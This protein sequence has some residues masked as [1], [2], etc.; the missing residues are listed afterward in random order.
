MSQIRQH[1]DRL[2]AC[3]DGAS[4]GLAVFYLPAVGDHVLRFR[5]RR[6]W[7]TRSKQTSAPS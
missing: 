3:A 2:E 1:C 5:G 6:V 4:P 7:V